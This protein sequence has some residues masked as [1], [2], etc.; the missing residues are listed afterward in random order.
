[1]AANAETIDT[2]TEPSKNP[3]DKAEEKGFK[4]FINDARDQL[5]KLWTDTFGSLN[6]RLQSTEGDL[7]EFVKRVETEGRGRLNR[8]IEALKLEKWSN[9]LNNPSKLRDE[10]VEQG[11]TLA[12]GSVNSLGLV[13]EAQFTAL[14]EEISALAE[15]VA[16]LSKKPAGATKKSVA[17]LAKRVKA[18]ETAS[19]ASTKKSAK[20]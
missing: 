19:K 12:K 3:A 17:D 8:I 14:S 5:E 20:K 7:K 9:T 2:T 18:L 10:L 13:T 6:G 15:A 4:T 16:K 11:Q 1:M